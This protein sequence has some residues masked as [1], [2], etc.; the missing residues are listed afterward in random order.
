MSLFSLFLSGFK[1]QRRQ[2]CSAFLSIIVAPGALGRSRL[3][4]PWADFH[5][6][7]TVSVYKS[8]H[9][10]RYRY[11]DLRIS[12]FSQDSDLLVTFVP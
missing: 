10:L 3:L 8:V 12:T 2:Q 4:Y 1:R 9:C 6:F 5:P 7:E 11:K